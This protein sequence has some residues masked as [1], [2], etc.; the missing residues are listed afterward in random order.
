MELEALSQ[1]LPIRGVEANS[2]RVFNIWGEIGVGKTSFISEFRESELMSKAK[3]LWIQPTRNGP[4]DTIPEFIRACAKTIRYPAEPDKEKKISELLESVQRGKINPIVSD[5]SILITRSSI[6]KQKK[7]YINQAAA[8]SVGRTEVVRDDIEINVG[9]GESK[10]TN[11]AEGFLDAL[12]LQSLGTDLTIIYIESLEKLSVSIVDWL[13]DYVFPAATRGAYRRSL[14]FLIESLDPIKLAYPNENWGE[15]SNLLEDFRLYPL[16]NNDVYEFGLAAGLEPAKAKFLR[17]KSLGYPETTHQAIAKLKSLD[18]SQ[19]ERFLATLPEA[20]QLKVAALCIPESLYPDDLDV[21]FGSKNGQSTFQWFSQLPN[22]QAKPSSTGKSLVLSDALRCVAINRFADSS[23]LQ[24]YAKKWTPM[25]RVVRNVPS[26]SQR[27]KLLLLSGLF[28]IDAALCKNLFGEQA[29][30]ILP[31]I[32]ETPLVFNR[33]KECYRISE[34]LRSDLQKS[35]QLMSH[36][37]LGIVLKKASK[38]WAETQEKLNAQIAELEAKIESQQ[39]EINNLARKQSETQAQIRIHER[40]TDD[41]QTGSKPSS[42]LPK[43]LRFSSD[44]QE[45]NDSPAGLKNLLVELNHQIHEHEQKSDELA[46]KL[47]TAKQALKFP[48]V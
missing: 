6:A 1:T 5:D 14:V 10:S 38:L 7:P 40:E 9:L 11:H 27:S 15:W 17:Y 32:T 26:R 34:R 13:R 16:S 35:A 33:Q 37:G 29:E 45:E 28:W 23:D 18:T 8:S 31:F 3:V 44:N 12:P 30:K 21:L 41:T 36:P 46:A 25:G 20:D 42:I 43:W 19:A 4:L 39:G 48:F 47:E 24:T 22:N 2:K